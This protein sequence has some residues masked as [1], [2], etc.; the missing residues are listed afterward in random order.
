MKPLFEVFAANILPALLIALAGFV[1]QRVLRLDP[2]TISR[3]AFYVLLPSLTFTILVSAEIATADIGKMMLLAS[4]V[5][6]AVGLVSYLFTRALRMPQPMA[7]AFILSA[8][9]MNAGNLGLPVNQF[10]F[11]PAGL[12][13]ASLFFVANSMLTNA[14][15]VYVASVGRSS[16]LRALAGLLKVPAVY[17]I[18]LALAIRASGQTIPLPLDRAVSLLGAAAVPMMLFLLGMQVARSGLP[19]Q[20]GYLGLA[21]GLRLIASPLLAWMILPL[22]GLPSLAN[23]VAVVEAAMPTAVLNTIIATEFEAEPGFVAGA[24]LVTTLV[25]PLTLTPILAW[26]TG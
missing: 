14:V 7:A 16:P 12:A 26:L 11:G 22:F 21:G 1:T 23:Q 8:T 3:V 6:A 15:G 13:W 10:A 18:P 24:V 5:I 19:R 9:F 4:T 25:S 20:V 17:A 2:R